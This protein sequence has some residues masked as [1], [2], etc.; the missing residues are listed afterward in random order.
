M[1]DRNV[2]DFYSPQRSL[3]PTSTKPVIGTCYSSVNLQIP[4]AARYH[5]NKPTIAHPDGSSQSHDSFFFTI[6]SKTQDSIRKN[7]KI[8]LEKQG[9]YFY[10]INS[11]GAAPI[12][13][14]TTERTSV[15]ESSG[16]QVSS[17]PEEETRA[18]MPQ[19]PL[20]F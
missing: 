13:L 17:L 19:C 10:S 20:G 11:I 4:H 6:L 3:H 7:Q 2:A 18:E 5:L 8:P 14:E 9:R 16:P 1:P 15:D 12:T